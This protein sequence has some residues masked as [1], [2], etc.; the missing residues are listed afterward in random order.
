MTVQKVSNILNESKVNIFQEENNL[1]GFELF[2]QKQNK[3]KSKLI[4]NELD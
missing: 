1:F 2:Y 3:E 4:P